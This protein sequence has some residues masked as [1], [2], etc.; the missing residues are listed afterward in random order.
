MNV[1]MEIGES[2][3]KGTFIDVLHVLGIVKNL[4]SMNKAISLGHMF[5]FR[6]THAH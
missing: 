3:V 1:T 4:F 6:T 2:I 5:E